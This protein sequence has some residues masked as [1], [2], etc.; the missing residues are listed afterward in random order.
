MHHA[1]KEIQFATYIHLKNPEK[2]KKIPRCKPSIDKQQSFIE[3]IK[4]IMKHLQK[5]DELFITK[6]ELILST[7]SIQNMKEKINSI[8]ELIK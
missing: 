7:H 2:L 8:Q 4:I 6:N 1:K 5:T 3:N